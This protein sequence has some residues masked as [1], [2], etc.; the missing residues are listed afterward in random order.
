VI[1]VP[2]SWRVG[3]RLNRLSP[4]LGVYLAR[5][6]YEDTLKRGKA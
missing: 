5:K 4:S 6:D 2:S 3:W 1:V